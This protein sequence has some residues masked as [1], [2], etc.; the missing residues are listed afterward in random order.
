MYQIPYI[1]KSLFMLVCLVVSVVSIWFQA[2]EDSQD[3]YFLWGG[4]VSLTP[5]PQLGGPGY[6][7][8]SG[9]SP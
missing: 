6:P 2:S 3:T 5:N 1:C 8:E 9:S 7:I 4:V